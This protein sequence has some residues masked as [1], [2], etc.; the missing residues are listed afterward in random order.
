MLCLGIVIVTLVSLNLIFSRVSTARWDL[1]ADARFTLSPATQKLLNALDDRLTIKVF[2][3]PNL[4]NPDQT[5]RQRLQDLLAEFEANAHGKLSFEIIEPQTQ[6]DEEIA[7]GFGLRKVA[8]SQRDETQKS[9]RLVFKGM[10]LRYRDMAETLPELRST[11]NL[12]YLIAKS[13]VNLTAPSHKTVSVL[14]GFGGLAESNILIETMQTMFEEV[15]GKHVSV[16]TAKINDNCTFSDHSDALVI[17]NINKTL[18]SCAQYAIEQAAFH[19]TALAI[20]QSPAQGDLLQP[21]QPRFNVDAGLNPILE[22]AGI[23]LNADLLLDRVHNIVGTQF[24][25]DSSVPVSQP[26]LPILT[27]LDKTHP[28]T[29]NLSAIVVPFG[30]TLTIDDDVIANNHGNLSLLAV[31]SPQSV[32]RPSGGDVYIEALKK[33]RDNEVPGPHKVIVA[34]QTPQKSHFTEHTLPDA[35]ITEQFTKSTERARYLIVP[36]GE[37]LF[38]NKLIG[39]P[40]ELAHLGIHL[41][42]NGIEWLVQDDAL[43]KIRNRALPQMFSVPS[44]DVRKR[45]IWMNVVGVPV[46]VLLCFGIIRFIRRYRQKRIR[47]MFEKRADN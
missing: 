41:F 9:L 4:P 30:G 32:T 43:I 33:S 6:T 44:A 28:I 1:T 16:Q 21:D 10:T 31:S 37:I 3:S 35:A 29:Q 42:V 27:E 20:F 38:S 7:K 34:L 13:I 12:E 47:R 23:Q 8:V 15:F 22:N 14:T 24:T 11:D 46:L 25:E 45:I 26:A 39:Y 19:G 5:L 2:L 18:S 36:S 17:L 40:D